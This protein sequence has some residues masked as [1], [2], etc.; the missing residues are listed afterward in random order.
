MADFT[1]SHRLTKRDRPYGVNEERI[2]GAPLLWAALQR[3]IATYQG[4]FV[5][6]APGGEL[7]LWFDYDLSHTFDD[8]PGWLNQLARKPRTDAEL[9]FGSQ[10]PELK[11]VATRDGDRITLRA[12]SIAGGQASPSNTLAL[13]VPAGRFFSEWK[14]FLSAV[15]DALEEFE[16]KLSN[17]VEFLSYRDA[18]S[19]IPS[20]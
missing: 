16:P 1:I 7:E 15:L 9:V 12:V 2:A 11:L 17:D 8:L 3:F 4:I 10:G 20:E 14:R 5:V 19:R 13:L 18:L 6:P